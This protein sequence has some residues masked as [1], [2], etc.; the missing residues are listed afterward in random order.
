MMIKN[1]ELEALQARIR[2][3]ESRLKNRQSVSIEPGTNPA[4]MQQKGEEAQQP[5]GKHVPSV[6]LFHRP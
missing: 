5:A 3:A 2:E 6:C 1:R 4:Q